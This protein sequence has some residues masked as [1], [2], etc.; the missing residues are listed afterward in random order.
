MADWEQ[1]PD[2][3]QQTELRERLKA[4]SLG[5]RRL[6]SYN[7]SIGTKKDGRSLRSKLKN[8]RQNLQEL[9]FALLRQ[10]EEEKGR[11]SRT[12]LDKIMRDFQPLLQE[13]ETLVSNIMEKEK[14]ITQQ[15][16]SSSQTGK[17]SSI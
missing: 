17:S 4:F 15:L 2:P 13:Y 3:A 11:L 7:E 9:S 1:K 8:E 10:I 5:I 16:S 14:D 12:Q 6:K